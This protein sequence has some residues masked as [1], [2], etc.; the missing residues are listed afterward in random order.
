MIETIKKL[1]EFAFV[2]SVDLDFMEDFV[3]I[4]VDGSFLNSNEWALNMIKN[5]LAKGGV[6]NY[7]I[8]V[9]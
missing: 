1:E 5:T 6:W 2:V 4:Y 3:Y 9:I 8:E 7:S